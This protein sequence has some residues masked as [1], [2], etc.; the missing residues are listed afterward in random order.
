MT[1]VMFPYCNQRERDQSSQ[2]IQLQMWT[3]S[4]LPQR[5]KKGVLKLTS[6]F[7]IVI[8]SLCRH[9]LNVIESDVNS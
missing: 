4:A 3:L 7:Q 1:Q 5:A 8:K 2:T 9:V 6:P